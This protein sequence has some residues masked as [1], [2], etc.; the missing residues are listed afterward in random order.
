MDKFDGDILWGL[1]MSFSIN[2]RRY[3]GCKAKLSGWIY[4]TITNNCKNSTSFCDLFAGTG[5][6]TSSLIDKFDTFFIND[7]LYSNEIIYKAFF[8]KQSYSE[9]KIYKYYNLF[10]NFQPKNIH[11]N[12][13]SIN[14][15]D[16]FFS[17]DDAL[18]I[19][20]IRDYI[21]EYKYDL[22]EKEYAILVASL[23]Y[24]ADRSSNTCGHYDAYIKKGVVRSSFKFELIEP[25]IKNSDDRRNI[26]ITR[27]N[28]N[29]LA[30][31]IKSDIIYIDPPY[32][33]RQYSR[34]YHVLETLT[35][36]DKP[37]LFGVARKPAQENM[38]EYCKSK[39]LDAFKELIYLLDSKYIVVSYNNTYNSKSSSSKNKMSLDEIKN[40][41]YNKGK[42]EIYSI[43]HKP[44][45]TGKTELENHQEM[46][47]VTEVGAF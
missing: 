30:S 7:F 38:S 16:K 42:T 44:F 28:S 10:H 11:Q 14:F 9:E 2:N 33:S 35:K 19:G 47:F 5:V 8:M 29:K 26:I 27:E 36:W 41:M 23:L 39:A 17:E 32:S 3:T 4:E 24:S 46:L 40:V 22:N 43:A 1:I 34:F 37:E 20:A 18:L 25:M 6:V 31:K 12:Y 15:G 21:E 13:V 45:N